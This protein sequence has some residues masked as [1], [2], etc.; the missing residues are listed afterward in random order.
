MEQKKGPGYFVWGAC[1]PEGRAYRDTLL[2]RMGIGE[3]KK[4][5]LSTF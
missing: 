2:H 1:R 3:M 4:R 5:L